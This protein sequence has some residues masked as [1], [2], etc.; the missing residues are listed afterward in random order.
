MRV[1]IIGGGIAGLS[2]AQ[3]LAVARPDVEIVV[4]EGSDRIG[5]KLRLGE[6]GGH[7]VD[8]GAESILARRPEGIDLIKAVG[9][10]D[11]LVHP[12]IVSAGIWTHDAVRPMPPTVMGIP[13]D[14]DALDAS[15]I[16]AERPRSIA[17]PR[18][19]ADMAVADFISERIGSDIV[20]RLV[21]PLLGG[22]YAGHASELSLDA[23]APQIAALGDDLLAGATKARAL[24][25]DSGPVF[26]GLVGGIGQLPEAV[27]RASGAEIRTNATVRQV[28]R[29]EDGWELVVGPTTAV[30]VIHV[31]AVI[32]AAPAPA[33]AR[34]LSVEAPEAAF[35]LAAIGCASM[36]V[37]TFAMPRAS[38]PKAPE[39]SGFLVPP[40]DGKAI[41][42]VT[43]SSNKWEWVAREAGEEMVIFRCSMGRAGETDLLQRDDAELIAIALND[44]GDAVGLTG[45]PLD[46]V[47]TRWGG[48]LPQYTVGHLKRVATIDADIATVPGLE[49]C[50]AT[51][52]GVG[53][54][55]VIA[56]AK[57]AVE[58]LLG[59]LGSIDT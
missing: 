11:K 16:I 13:A 33:A 6:I 58:R 49:V 34:L 55:A 54:P 19:P 56:S 21:E 23:A 17:I 32:M 14:L 27:A 37:I 26:A 43:Y 15:G 22:V 7:T 45:E 8:F 59:D 30:E 53:I 39:G 5:G 35:A 9:L 48:G 1:A 52:R 2:A 29:T 47:V 10:G 20:D 24:A 4:L 46:A 18:P 38:F 57:G 41:K 12:A 28:T 31:D 42:A 25:V 51:Y 40:V 36:A 3:A 50:G 44:L